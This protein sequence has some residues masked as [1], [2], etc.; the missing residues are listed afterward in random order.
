M[1]IR[2][3]IGLQGGGAHGAFTWGVLDRLLAEEDIEIAGIS[4]TSAGA[5]NGAALKAGLVAGGCE[6]AREN[7]DWLWQK[8]GAIEEESLPAWFGLTQTRAISAALDYAPG[9]AFADAIG[10]M[11]SPYGWGPFY[12]NPLTEI[13]EAL[14]YHRVCAG[15]G[16]RFFVGA[17]NVRTGKARVFTGEEIDTQAILASACLP[18]LFQAV[19]KYDARSDR[20]EAFWDGGYTG[21]PPL[22]PLFERDLPDDILVVNINPL[23][24]EQVP[25]TP[26]DIRNR[27]NEISFNSSLL[28]EIRAIGFVARLI[29][30]GVVPEGAMKRVRLHMIHDDDLMN[31]LSV[32]TKMVPVPLVMGRLKAAGQAAADHFLDRHKGALGHADTLNLAEMFG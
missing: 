22:W 19:E 3:N 10:R 27:V 20:V 21:N 29:D 18:T 2:I 12:S 6:G 17:T 30:E 7:L 26:Q 16:P 4:G 28:R 24:R 23:C 5:L 9:Y 11:M 1:T 31:D 25:M 13:V 14:D 32:A 15:E 8:I